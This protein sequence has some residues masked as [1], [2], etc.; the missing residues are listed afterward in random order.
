MVATLARCCWWPPSSRARAASCGFG[1]RSS[2]R[3]ST[4][5]T[6]PCS[7][8]WSSRCWS[9]IR[10]SRSNRPAHV[11][12]ERGP[13]LVAA[14]LVLVAVLALS[15]PSVSD[16]VAA[17]VRETPARRWAALALAVAFT[18]I[19]LLKALTTDEL[20]GDVQGVNLPWTLNDAMAVLDGR[21]P[22]VDYHVIY[23]KLLPYPTALALA[24]FGTTT[25]VYT[26]FMAVLDGLVLVAIYATF[27]LVT[28]S[29]LLALG[30]FVPFV[31]ASDVDPLTD[32]AGVGSP[33]TLSAM[34]PMR[35]GGAYLLAWLIARHVAGRRPHRA[36]VV[37]LVGGL[38]ALNTLE[39]GVGAIVA[40]VAAL[41]C[42]QTASLAARRGPARRERGRGHA[43]RTRRSSRWRRSRAPESARASTCC[44]SGRGSSRA[45]A[46]SR[47]RCRRG[48][49]TSRCTRRSRPPSSSP[50]CGPRAV[51]TTPLLTRD[52]RV[53]RRLRRCSPAATTSDDRTSSSSRASC[54]RGASRSSLLT[55]A[56]R[57]RT[58]GSRLAS[59]DACR[60]CSSSSASPSRS[61]MLGRL[62]PPQEQISRLT[63]S[64]PAPTYQASAERFVREHTR[65]GETVAILAADE[66]PHLARARARQRLALPV[67]ER[68]RDA[69]ADADADRRARG[70]SACARSS[71]PCPEASSPG[72]AT[73]R[74]RSS[75]PC[76]AS[77]TDAVTPALESA[78][79]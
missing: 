2:V 10:G 45:S 73:P 4:G 57:A 1:P 52:A 38:V 39:F 46:G 36:W 51:T 67:H 6:R 32:P 75:G 31:A 18:A 44:S 76:S 43:R 22:L 25:F 24:A 68:D 56:V 58:G 77:A 17:L 15:R 78:S 30:L 69:I 33:M 20:A 59:P 16:R 65:P 61:C 3:S 29:S 7:R 12:F 42:A 64:R 48:T 63:A 35:Y 23:A 19:W 60:S 50:Q 34:W 79:S 13:I 27:R 71:C 49:C 21:T 9:S 28:R 72:R 47:C 14:I 54:R 70:G 62:T 8:S 40:S 66:L 55:V 41:L 5:D 11:I 53:E 26:A 74:R 37:F